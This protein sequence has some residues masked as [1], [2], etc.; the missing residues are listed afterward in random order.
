M[1]YRST[2]KMFEEFVKTSIW[3]DMKGELEK[4]LEDIRTMLED[5]E[6]SL[7]FGGLKRLQGSADAVRNMMNLPENVMDNIEEDNKR[8]REDKEDGGKS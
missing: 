6:G 5:V 3:L 4:W 2:P 1:E 8:E 7:D